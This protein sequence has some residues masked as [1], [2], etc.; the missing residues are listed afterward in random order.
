MPRKPRAIK[1]Q[2]LELE[3]FAEKYE[4]HTLVYGDPTEVVFD[5]MAS[6]EDVSVETR[7][8][9]AEILMSYRYPR[10]KALENA[11]K[12]AQTINIQIVSAVQPTPQVELDVSPR[13]LQLLA[14]E[15][16]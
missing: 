6:K 2:K 11:P 5:I 7:L 15:V 16:K 13:E 10:L 1:P 12:D 3:E 8:R 4:T 9:A 14:T